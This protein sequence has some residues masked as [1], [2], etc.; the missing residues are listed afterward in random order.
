MLKAGFKIVLIRNGKIPYRQIYRD[1][2]FLSVYC[3]GQGGSV[4]AWF[5][6]LL[7]KWYILINPDDHGFLIV[8]PVIEIRKPQRVYPAPSDFCRIILDKTEMG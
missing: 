6:F 5:S 7:F 1:L 4:F 2:F 8:D 3:N